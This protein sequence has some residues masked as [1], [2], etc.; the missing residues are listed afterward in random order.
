MGECGEKNT[1]VRNPK[2]LNKRMHW[3][4]AS[5]VRMIPS[6]LRPAPDD[7]GRWATTSVD[8]MP[9][10]RKSMK[11]T[12]L[13]IAVGLLCFALLSVTEAH[14]RMMPLTS[15]AQTGALVFKNVT[16]IDGTGTSAQPAMTVVI[17]QD[18]IEA[19]GKDGQ[20]AIP[21]GSRVVNASGKFLIP[22]LWDMH[23]H[24]TDAKPSA[25]PALVANGV[26]RVR[27]MGSL[28]KELDGWRVRIEDGTLIGPRIFRAGPILNGKEFGPVHLGA[29]DATEARAAIRTLAKVGVDFIK[30]HMTLTRDQYL[31]IM[32]EAKKA[33]LPVVGHIPLA[34][35]PEEVSDSGQASIEHTESLFQGTFDPRVPRQ[36][37]LAQMTALFQRFARNNTFYTPTLIMYK[38]SADL[39]ER[40]PHPQSKYVARSAHER[41][42]QAAEQNKK[43]PDLA[44]GRKRILADL[45]LLV[46]MMRQNGV[47]VMT[48]TDLADGRI[49]PGFSLH[50]ELALLVEAGFS[51][52][53][54]IQAAT[55]VPAEFLRLSDAGT[56]QQ[57]KRADLVLLSANPLDDIRNTTKIDA[58]VLRGQFLDRAHLDAMRRDGE[59]LAA[60]H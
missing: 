50:E 32:D 7:A 11:R 6:G 22:G 57:G 19:I 3:S 15:S 49:F 12:Y 43:Y 14:K 1:A 5:E 30:I 27:D 13:L 58:V 21:R 25:I 35:T 34:V 4:A 48:G 20:L 38:A 60:K 40:T 2:T 46:G 8:G 51:P 39:Q 29:A 16:V 54:A 23:V 42:L 44:A 55:R 52:N 26:T 28:L 10:R 9:K 31:A 53:E 47:R 45:I 18:R 33:G 36:Q 17:R 37:M 56:I 41:M 24:L 59:G